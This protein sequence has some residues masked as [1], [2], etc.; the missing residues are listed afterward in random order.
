MGYIGS[1]IQGGEGGG[2]KLIIHINSWVVVYRLKNSRRGGG[3]I[4]YNRKTLGKGYI[5]YKI[6]EGGVG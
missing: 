4:S 1:K 6:Q 2:A 3:L 5:T